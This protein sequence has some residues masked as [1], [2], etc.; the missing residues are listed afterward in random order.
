LLTL[1]TWLTSL[2][3]DAPPAAMDEPSLSDIVSA[4]IEDSSYP[5]THKFFKPPPEARY[6]SNRNVYTAKEGPMQPVAAYERPLR[7]VDIDLDSTTCISNFDPPITFVSIYI[8]LL[9]PQS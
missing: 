2:H 7:P 5:K 9:C 1:Q 4:I 8:T 3:E 6:W